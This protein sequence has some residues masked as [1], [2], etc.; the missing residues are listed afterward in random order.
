MS[1]TVAP[2]GSGLIERAKNILL[3]PSRT[4][5]EIAAEPSSVRS[6]Y[7]GYVLPL[8]AIGPIASAIGM[9][10]FGMNLLFMTYRTPIQWAVSGAIVQYI[11]SLVMVY[12]LALV[13]DALAPSFGGEKNQLQAFKL[14]AYS[15]T[16]SWLAAIF[17]IFPMLGVLGLLGLY[18][19]YLL[20]VGLPRLMKSPAE[21]SLGYTI[22]II[23]VMIVCGILIGVITSPIYR[24]GASVPGVPGVIGSATPGA[25]TGTVNVP[26][27]GSVDLGKLQAATQQME[28]QASAMQNGQTTVKL[29]DPQALLNLMPASYMGAARS[30]TETT[31]NAAGGVAASSAEATYAVNGGTIRLK[32]ADM[33]SLGGL[34][35]MAQAMNVNHTETTA[36]GYKKV[37]S[38]NGHMESEDYN[39]TSK[40][41][42]YT[43]M[44][45]P[46]ISIEANGEGV[47]MAAIKGLVASVNSGAAQSLAQ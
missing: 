44:A 33:G 29:A 13:I 9:S 22:V 12:V 25:V 19:L 24:L 32:I 40:S 45:G 21:K 23:I 11:L 15:A 34:G 8:A 17:G 27:A 2:G 37:V 38:Q 18:S 10:V 46:R 31:S 20:F 35:A 42:S 28:A 3:A 47:D 7:M 16:A 6:I 36:D 14:A 1:E 26:G 43:I 41:G 5:D 4:W 39:T 30:D